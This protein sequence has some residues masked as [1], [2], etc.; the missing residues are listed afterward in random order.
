MIISN[1]GGG[2][3]HLRVLCLLDKSFDLGKLTQKP[4]LD[5]MLDEVY[6]DDRDWHNWLER[7]WRY[8]EIF[9]DQILFTHPTNYPHKDGEMEDIINNDEINPILYLMRDP[10][11]CYRHYLKLNSSLNS[12][13]KEQFLKDTD[14]DSLVMNY[15]SK[16]KQKVKI[17]QGDFLF[18]P[19][20][21]DEKIA[22]INRFFKI[23]ID[24][25]QAQQVHE[26]WYNLNRKAEKNIVKDIAKIYEEV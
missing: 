13:S 6:S 14:N 21:Q 2:G 8:H 9:N 26:K 12:R 24:I 22:E 10:E 15:I 17:M 4:K 18:N 16:K 20:L 3:N 25:N 1:I 19:K 11:S 5:F 7:E 23:D